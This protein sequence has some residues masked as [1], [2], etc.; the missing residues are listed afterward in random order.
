MRIQVLCSRHRSCVW[1]LLAGGGCVW[2]VGDKRKD[3]AACVDLWPAVIARAG[4]LHL[5]Y[6]SYESGLR[7]KKDNNRQ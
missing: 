4:L 2:A 1:P 6:V 5:A 7:L 3:V